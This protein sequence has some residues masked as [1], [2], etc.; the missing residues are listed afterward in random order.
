MNVEQAAR[1]AHEVN[2]VYC[3]SLGDHS[4]PL[5]EDAPM[6]Q[7][8]S[9]IHGIQ[10]HWDTMVIGEEL[11]PSASHEA[12]LAEKKAAGWKWGRVKDVEK[13]EHPC[14]VP[15]DELPTEQK[16]KNFLFDAVAKSTFE[17][18]AKAA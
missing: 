15:Y 13:K 16:T 7:R 2:R 6:W 3:Q 5:W 14:F 8:E 10:L 17:K 11:P 1:I 18:R 9:V 4:Q 12:W